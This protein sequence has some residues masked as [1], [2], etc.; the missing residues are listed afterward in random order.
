MPH[1]LILKLSYDEIKHWPL[2][3]SRSLKHKWTPQVAVD[4]SEIVS[5]CTT[6]NMCTCVQPP[7]PMDMLTCVYLY[8]CHGMNIA[9]IPS[10]RIL[11]DQPRTKLA[12]YLLWGRMFGIKN[13]LEFSGQT[14]SLSENRLYVH[15]NITKVCSY[16]SLVGTEHYS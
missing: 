9:E 7:P 10:L 12:Q 11:M 15:T 3:E 6:I 8:N 5:C 2:P 13:S 1:W 14:Q 4:S 16:T